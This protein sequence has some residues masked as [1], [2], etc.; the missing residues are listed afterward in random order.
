MEPSD[1]PIRRYNHVLGFIKENKFFR[2]SHAWVSS[3]PCPGI[4]SP[5]TWTS[6][7]NQANIGPV[8][9][10]VMDVMNLNIIREC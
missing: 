2:I 8:N 5:G 3:V 7:A 6:L 1:P 9:Q 4:F 10:S